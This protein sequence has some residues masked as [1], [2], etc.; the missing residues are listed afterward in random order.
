MKKEVAEQIR[1]IFAATPEVKLAYLF[2]SQATGEAG[3]LSDYDF[4]VY[5]DNRHP[6]ET[7]ALR[8]RLQDKLG[9]ALHTEAVDVVVL[10]QVN[11]P[12][13]KYQVI[14]QGKLLFEREP[15][16]LEAEPKILNEYFDFRTMLRRYGLTRA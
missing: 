4:A 7:F 1:G 10:D 9:R 16:R 2:G 15:F 12:E 11:S 5:L 3:A 6:I 8:A 13:L 14:S